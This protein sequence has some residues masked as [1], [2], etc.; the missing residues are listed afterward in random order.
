MMYRME[1]K[2]VSRFVGG[3]LALAVL[4][5]GCTGGGSGPTDVPPVQPSSETAELPVTAPP[6]ATEDSS[7]IA[8]EESPTPPTLEPVVADTPAPATAN[9]CTVKSNALNVREGPGTGFLVL[10][11]LAHAAVFVPMERD[12]GT[13]WL[14]GESGDRRG[15]VA[16]SNLDCNFDPA[17][18]PV[19]DPLPPTYTPRPPTAT[20]TPFNPLQAN[21]AP[22]SGVTAQLS[23]GVT[24][25]IRSMWCEPPAEGL[26]APVIGVPPD[27][28]PVGELT[29]VCAMGFPPG[30][31]VEFSVK[32]SDGSKLKRTITAEDSGIAFWNWL[33][34]PGAPRGRYKVV[35]TSGELRAEGSFKVKDPERPVVDV[36]PSSGPR[37]TAFRVS[38]AGFSPGKPVTLYLYRLFG[39]NYVY[40]TALHI[41]AADERGEAFSVIQSGMDDPAG[42]YGLAAVK[43]PIATNLATFDVEG[44]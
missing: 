5:A 1:I 23:E 25:F 19:A 43:E 29:L 36:E 7:G 2:F 18:L 16:R 33:S 12:P 4:V 24:F 13:N 10:G 38:A 8:A 26:D 22:P 35:A 42:R 41:G 32:R 34:P 31:D 17:E 40:A 9:Q 14:R 28:A 6:E 44:G 27:D 39:E 37:G 11:G 30:A 21:D 15:W 20:P 3:S